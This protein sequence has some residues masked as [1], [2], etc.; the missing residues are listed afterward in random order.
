[1]LDGEFG[2]KVLPEIELNF[3]R[4]WHVEVTVIDIAGQ[5]IVNIYRT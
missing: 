2:C 5:V 4:D 3:V 1:M